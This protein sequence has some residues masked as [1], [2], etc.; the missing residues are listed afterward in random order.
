MV[1]DYGCNLASYVAGIAQI[2][3]VCF[4]NGANKKKG[5]PRA[6]YYRGT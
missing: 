1:F 6:K 3:K 4:K 5:R 2:L